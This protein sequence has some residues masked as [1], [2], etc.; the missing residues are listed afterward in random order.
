[1][2]HGYTCGRTRGQNVRVRPP[3]GRPGRYDFTLTFARTNLQRRRCR[4]CRRR[5]H[6]RH[7]RSCKWNVCNVRLA[8]EQTLPRADPVKLRRQITRVVTLAITRSGEHSKRS[9]G[10]KSNRDRLRTITFDLFLCQ[11]ATIVGDRGLR[12]DSLGRGSF[13]SCFCAVIGEVYR[14]MGG[15]V[16]RTGALIVIRI[17]F[18]Y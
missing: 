18:S 9:T 8:S 17:Q 6:R 11:L 16:D 3:P 15:F 5:R 14:T 13:W 10:R 1:M 2:L 12:T 7:E 4:R